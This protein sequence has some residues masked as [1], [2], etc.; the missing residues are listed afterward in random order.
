MKKYI[1]YTPART[2]STF[3]CRV[4]DLY[5]RHLYGTINNVAWEDS[6]NQL[7]YD[8]AFSIY[9]T[10]SIDFLTNAPDNFTKVIT[11]RSIIDS[12]LSLL[13]AYK[14]NI[15]HA[16]QPH[17]QKRYQLKFQNKKFYIDPDVFINCVRDYDRRY[18]LIDSYINNNP[19]NLIVLSYNAHTL[20]LKNLCRSLKFDK[21]IIN[22]LRKDYVII[23][24]GTRVLNKYCII[25][26]LNEIAQLYIKLNVRHN[27][28]D[29]YSLK[30]IF[31]INSR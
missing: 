12:T 29:A 9:H 8:S 11:T 6:S 31:K 14:T 16:D 21:K 15:W 19:D 28:D 23:N 27:F 10:H 24:G 13:I 25:E 4:L 22:I 18:D 5:Y 2:G 17:E 3:Y 1:V 30:Q 7:F 20:D 26:N